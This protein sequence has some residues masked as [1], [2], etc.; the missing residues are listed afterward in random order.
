MSNKGPC[1]AVFRVFNDF[2][3]Y[4]NEIYQHVTGDEVGLHAVEVIG[5]SDSGFAR[6]PG[7]GIGAKTA[8]SG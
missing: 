2:F 4:G 7:V 8:F 3:S 6:I 1:V 5:Y